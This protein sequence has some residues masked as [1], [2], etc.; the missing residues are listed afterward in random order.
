[1]KYSVRGEMSCP[2]LGWRGSSLQQFTRF[3]HAGRRAP[4]FARGYAGKGGELT[5]PV[6]STR[7]V[8]F[9]GNGSIILFGVER[10]ILA[11]SIAQQEIE[12][13]TR[14]VAQFAVTMHDRGSVTLEILADRVVGFAEQSRRLGAFDL[15]DV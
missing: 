12:N 2:G 10:A 3:G 14:A 15:S 8:K 7:G 6:R 11:D 4:V 5:P 13:G 1:M 9:F